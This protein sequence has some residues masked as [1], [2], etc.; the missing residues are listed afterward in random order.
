M[1]MRGMG[2][3]TSLPELVN[4][5]ISLFKRS[6]ATVKREELPFIIDL[7]IV[8]VYLKYIESIC[9]RIEVEIVKRYMMAYQFFKGFEQYGVQWF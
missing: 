9:K 8:G 7:I 1:I 2:R 3:L 6:M 5:S 4:E